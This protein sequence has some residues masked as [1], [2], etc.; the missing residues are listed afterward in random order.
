MPD[1]YFVLDSNNVS[2]QSTMFYGYMVDGDNI[3]TCADPLMDS[4]INAGRLG[5]YVYI[6]ASANDIT[7]IVA[8]ND[9]VSRN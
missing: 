6:S 7:I 4:G 2:I 8:L 9:I 3:I 5:C 1:Q